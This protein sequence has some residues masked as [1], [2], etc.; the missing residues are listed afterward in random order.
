MTKR[1]VEGTKNST[2]CGEG[3]PGA[4]APAQ[5][6]PLGPNPGG[7]MPLP[8]APGPASLPVIRI[9]TL[10][11]SFQLCKLPVSSWWGTSCISLAGTQQPAEQ[12]PGGPPGSPF[13]VAG[14]VEPTSSA[15][16]VSSYRPYLA[17]A[18]PSG[19]VQVLPASKAFSDATALR[20]SSFSAASEPKWFP[21]V[22]SSTLAPCSMA[23]LPKHP[24]WL[25]VRRTLGRCPSRA[26]GEIREVSWVFLSPRAPPTHSA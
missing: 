9:K 10:S 11:W 6:L 1:L 22:V 21:A 2:Y 18:H 26:P 23:L 12:T 4:I 13:G 24:I 20:A 3:P 15:F 5:V 7:S 25:P 17:S 19:P 8:L 14:V 16:S